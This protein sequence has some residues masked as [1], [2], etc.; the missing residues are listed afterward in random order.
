MPGP[1]R[2]SLAERFEEK[3]DRSPGHGPWGDCHL[4]TAGTQGHY[5]V[6]GSGGRRGKNLL[7]HRVAWLLQTGEW[8]R[9]NVLH[10]CD[11]TL[12]VNFDHL[13]VGTQAE[14]VRDCIEKGRF[15]VGRRD[16]AHNGRARLNEAAVAEIRSSPESGVE[17]ARRFGVSTSTISAARRG[18]TWA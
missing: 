13:T 15:V 17:L 2:R 14:N 3:V 10:R 9:L 16:R 7:A 6:I 12:C 8:P 18:K 11:I 1:R 5:G 4:W